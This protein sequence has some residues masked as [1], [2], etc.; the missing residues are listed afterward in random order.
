MF[1]DFKVGPKSKKA[2]KRAKDDGLRVYACTWT[3]KALSNEH[4]FRVEN[5]YGE[6]ILWAG[7][8]CLNNPTMMENSLAW[9]REVLVSLEVNGIVLDGV[10]FPSPGAGL[11]V[12]PNVFLRTLRTKS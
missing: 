3:F 1:A 7:A 4:K 6:R 9:V 2:I 12:F 5:I 10:R 8:G 11:S